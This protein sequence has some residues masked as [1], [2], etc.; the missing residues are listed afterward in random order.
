MQLKNNH[1]KFDNV[2]AVK[3]FDLMSPI[4]YFFLIFMNLVQIGE[5]SNFGGNSYH[6]RLVGLFQFLKSINDV[7]C[8]QSRSQQNVSI[9]FIIFEILNFNISTILFSV[10]SQMPVQAIKLVTLLILYQ[11]YT[12]RSQINYTREIHTCILI[13]TVSH[14]MY[15]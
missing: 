2:S 13:N 3:G 11:W 7:N 12:D 15:S 8:S 10:Y 9:V 1:Q 4:W 6:G 14:Q 5:M